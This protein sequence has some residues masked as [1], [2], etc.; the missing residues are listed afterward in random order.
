MDG[1]AR[2]F[3]MGLCFVCFAV[4]LGVFWQS[5]EGCWNCFGVAWDSFENPFEV[6]LTLLR[7]IWRLLPGCY[8]VASILL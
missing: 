2:A 6:V 7:V 1:E 5:C 3:C 4:A 8:K